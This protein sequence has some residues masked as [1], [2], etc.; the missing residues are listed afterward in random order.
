MSREAHH[1]S[2]PDSPLTDILS[3]SEVP[4]V[5][6]MGIT[7]R[8]R[9]EPDCLTP[10]RRREGGNEERQGDRERMREKRYSD[11]MKYIDS[12]GIEEGQI[13]TKAVASPTLTSHTAGTQIPL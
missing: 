2:G 12:Q 11:T 8:R 4:N 5:Q 13:E 1:L 9:E 7:G 3:E 6:P 10:P